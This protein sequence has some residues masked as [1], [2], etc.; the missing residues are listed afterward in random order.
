MGEP[1]AP[2]T[3]VAT[4][5]LYVDDDP[6]HRL[7]AIKTLTPS[8]FTVTTANNGERALRVFNVLSPE[9]V[10]LA[11]SDPEDGLKTCVALRSKPGGADLPIVISAGVED[12][13]AID[14]AYNAGATDFVTSPIRFAILAYRLRYLIRSARI[15]KDLR[16]TQE[17]LAAAQRIAKLGHWS[18]DPVQNTV[19]LSA[20]AARILRRG[21]KACD[22]SWDTFLDEVHDEDRH[23]IR[24]AFSELCPDEKTLHVEHRLLGGDSPTIVCQE[25]QA[26]KSTRG[27]SVVTGTIQDISERKRSE[28]HIIRLAYHDELTGLPNR[29]FLWDTLPNMV[30]DAKSRGDRLA[31][32]GVHL[33]GFHRIV[34]TFGHEAGDHLLKMVAERLNHIPDQTDTLVPEETLS[35]DDTY[36]GGDVLL[37]RMATDSFMFAFRDVQDLADAQARAQ[38]IQSALTEPIDVAGHPVV[39]NACLGLSL[40]PIHGDTGANLLKNAE[41]AQHQ[42]TARGSGSLIVFSEAV[43]ELARERMT[44]EVALRRAIDND[45]LELHYQPKVDAVSGLPVGMEALLRWTHDE[46]GP[47]RPDRFVAIAEESG[48]IIKLGTW[49]LK[50]AC[51]QTQSWRTSGFSDLRV[52]VNISV[53]QFVQGDFVD[54][55][56]QALNDTGLPP[57]A[58][59]LE[60]T[61][62]L[63]MKDTNL[64]VSHLTELRDQ[65]IHIALDDF[66]TGYSSL[67]Y[68]HRFPFDTLKID[69]SFIT[70]MMHKPGTA[71]IVRAII[72][73]SHN[74]DLRVVAEGVEEHEQL[75]E[76]RKLGCEEIQGFLFSRALPAPAFEAWIRNAFKIRTAAVG[77]NAPSHVPGLG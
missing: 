27:Y 38:R 41:A 76:L 40:F 32:I 25:A 70:D 39:P 4:T 14:R 29:T 21:N 36:S 15:R 24:R 20:E 65:G 56:R 59:E 66:G 33:D 6:V 13:E 30:E 11:G 72:L 16:H 69:R 9:L 22:M 53:N 77:S 55:V 57:Q 64:A 75:I 62:G 42:A 43:H 52:A 5:I 3:D 48:L 46:L 10:V 2:T 51:A 31:L 1:K 47:I 68:L 49:V 8:G 61:E 23:R 67:S 37:A 28:R 50:T 18:W 19:K 63:L 58:L 60:I 34:D 73:L 44:L 54:V 35:L 74:L 7:L 12:V 17:Q 26:M 45:E 71:M